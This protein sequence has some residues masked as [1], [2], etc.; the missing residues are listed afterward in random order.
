MADEFILDI[1]EVHPTDSVAALKRMRMRDQSLPLSP[2]E[3]ASEDARCGLVT[4]VAAL[5]P[6]AQMLS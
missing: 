2:E 6:S 5:L 4:A 1:V 3:A